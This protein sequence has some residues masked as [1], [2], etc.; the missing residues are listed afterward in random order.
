MTAE[1]F[2]REPV[3]RAYAETRRLAATWDALVF[4]VTF[5]VVA[6]SHTRLLNTDGFLA[7]S[8]GREVWLHGLPV[9]DTL[10]V[11]GSGRS[12]IDQQW[13]AQLILYRLWVAGGY[14]AVT[15]VT[16][17]L[18]ALAFSLLCR[19]L[20]ERG[21]TPRRAIKWTTVALAATLVDVSARTQVFA[22][23]LFILL[24]AIIVRDSGRPASRRTMLSALGLLV[25]W[26]NLHGSVLVGVGLLTFH[27]VFRAIACRGRSGTLLYSMTA[28]AAPVT[29]FA[30][31][32]GL[33]IVHYYQS[34][35]DNPAIR[36]SS[37][38]WQPALPTN[39][40]AIGYWT[41]VLA[42]V[43]VVA[44]GWRKG[45][46]PSLELSILAVGL[47]IGGFTAIRWDGW[48]AMVGVVVATDVLNATGPRAARSAP[49]PRLLLSAAVA[50]VV[51]IVSLGI[52]DAGSFSRE[53]PLGA[54]DAASR[55]ARTHP[56]AKLLADDISSSAIVWL[57][58]QLSGR[59]AFDGRL[60]VFDQ[61]DVRQ[62]SNYIRVTPGSMHLTE[63]YQV[64]VA[65]ASNQ[66]LCHALR[67][68][69][70]ARVIYDGLDGIVVVRT[71]QK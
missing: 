46:R 28:I 27:C 2:S 58:P 43:A 31:P 16:A 69:P 7:L 60:E 57:H 10:T 56:R 24:L 21:A 18:T 4:L 70:N 51:L 20:L 37:S 47:A 33:S 3:A 53:T 26:A 49:S 62:W 22:Y 34:V 66:R 14:L 1:V 5:V 25:L 30:T 9:V 63:G 68:M 29:L 12:W 50:A 45:A 8:G 39:L 17:M 48:A 38:E 11:A 32:Y 64:F 19:L 44:W 42:V 35:L 61:A 59:V 55:Y 52:S 36:E 15:I 71:R 23:P 41:F 6:A 65:S 67:R 40:A 54:M 13:L